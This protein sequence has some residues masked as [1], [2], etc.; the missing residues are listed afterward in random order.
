[1]IGERGVVSDTPHP[2]ESDEIVKACEVCSG[3]GWLPSTDPYLDHARPRCEAC[4][5][6]GR[7]DER[8]QTV[9]WCVTHDRPARGFVAAVCPNEASCN[10]VDL[11]AAY[12]GSPQEASDGR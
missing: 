12:F 3:V 1:V 10:V 5:G 7:P 6:S 9:K 4:G 2:S 11:P 8:T